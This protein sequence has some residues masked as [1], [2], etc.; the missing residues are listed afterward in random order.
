M[1]I[2]IIETGGISVATG[3]PSSTENGIE[4]MKVHCQSVFET[5]RSLC[6]TTWKV[7]WGTDSRN[8]VIVASSL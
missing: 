1:L 8:V 2:Y 5:V 6:D 7:E 3:H 4:S